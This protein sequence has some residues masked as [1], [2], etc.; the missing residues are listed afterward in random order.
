MDGLSPPARRQLLSS[1]IPSLSTEECQ[2]VSSLIYSRLHVDILARLPLELVAA[3]AVYLPPWDVFVCRRVARRWN[4]LLSSP[5]VCRRCYSAYYEGNPSVSS[6]P[7]W[8]ALFRRDMKRQ[9]A[10]VTGR[11]YSRLFIPYPHDHSLGYVPCCDGRVVLRS[12]LY[13]VQLLSLFDGLSTTYHTD[14]RETVI[15]TGLSQTAVAAL[16]ANGYCHLWNFKSGEHGC[17]RLPSTHFYGFDIDQDFV[18]VSV[19]N[20]GTTIII[21]DLASKQAREIQRASRPICL[22]LSAKHASLTVVDLATDSA[23]PVPP[24]GRLRFSQAVG[25]TYS[26]S[27]PTPTLQYTTTY[28]KLAPPFTQLL[29][30]LNHSKAN[31]C[32]LTLSKTRNRPAPD[33][34]P[35]RKPFYIAFITHYPASNKQTTHFYH[36]PLPV[37][38][39]REYNDL[40]HIFRPDTVYHTRRSRVY[41]YRDGNSRLCEMPEIES[42]I[43]TDFEDSPSVESDFGV[44]DPD[45]AMED[46]ELFS[47]DGMFVG[48]LTETGINAW[49]FDEEVAPVHEVAEY[50]TLRAARA[51]QRAEERKSCERGRRERH[52]GE[53]RWEVP[54]VDGELEID[55]HAA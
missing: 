22:F 5:E 36:D 12:S 44:S 6:S 24:A 27:G 16:T 9:L 50:R 1:L 21:W 11:P 20:H 26:L 54:C 46:G 2:L 14:N 51:V 13:S 4:E 45:S 41:N 34:S 29:F 52:E 7:D 8:P 3:I 53:E 43:E 25:S 32:L 23:V 28:F 37:E 49:C 35:P 19:G 39:G 31:T 42:E 18:A 40:P 30:L 48:S 47:D 55:G 33:K 10:L 15:G 17:F 38:S